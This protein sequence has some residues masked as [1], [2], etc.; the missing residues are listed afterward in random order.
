MLDLR[1]LQ[2]QVKK[3]IC[4]QKLFW[5]FTVWINCSR[6]LKNFANSLNNHLNTFFSQQFRTFV[7]T[8]FHLTWNFRI[9]IQLEIFSDRFY[10]EGHSASR[11]LFFYIQHFCFSQCIH[12]KSWLHHVVS[13]RKRE[14]EEKGNLYPKNRF[15]CGLKGGT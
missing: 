13:F 3:A 11:K 5:P 12:H 2:E 8:K 15:V 10:Q 6:D 4:Y 9:S 1:N 14:R 7:V